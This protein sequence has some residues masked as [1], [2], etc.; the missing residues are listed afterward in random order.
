[1]AASSKFSIAVHVLSCLEYSD[2]QWGQPQMNSADL[3]LSVNTN[4]VIIRNLL[5]ELSKAGLVISKEGKGGGARLARAASAITLDEVYAAVERAEMLA[6][7]PRPAHLPCS[8]SCGVKNALEPV[9]GSVNH[10]ILSAL[11]EKNLSEIVDQ[12]MGV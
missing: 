5:S 7:N 12:I 8:V 3:A 1:M 10:A 9:L 2:R 11:K 4:P 6:R